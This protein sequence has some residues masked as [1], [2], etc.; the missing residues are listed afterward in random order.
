MGRRVRPV[1]GS[2]GDILLPGRVTSVLLAALAVVTLAGC[3]G[4]GPTT[5]SDVPQYWVD[6]IKQLL[7]APNVSDFE[8]ETLADF[9]V[10]DSEYQEARNG[11]V[12]GL[13]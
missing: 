9:R 8:R 4:G 11:R 13:V 7:S 5:P 3:T 10:S 2:I 1:S 12:P 6:T